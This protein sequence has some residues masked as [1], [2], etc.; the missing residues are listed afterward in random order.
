MSFHSKNQIQSNV[1]VKQERSILTFGIIV[2]MCFAYT[3]SLDL[4]PDTEPDV[5][6]EEVGE[7]ESEE[8]H[9]AAAP[10]SR[11]KDSKMFR[12]ETISQNF[13]KCK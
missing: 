10:D 13:V 5:F 8:N 6:D 11:N 4:F 3:A 9:V 1:H 12:T 2:F 7:V